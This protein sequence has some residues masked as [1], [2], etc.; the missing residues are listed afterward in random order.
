LW[1]A[2]SGEERQCGAEG[3]VRAGVGRVV[4]VHRRGVEFEEVMVGQRGDRRG[5]CSV[6]RGAAVGI[7]TAR[8][9]VEAGCERKMK[10]E[11][12]SSSAGWSF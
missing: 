5:R 2:L 11:R 4:E 1:H 8:G 12:G 6:D 7:S 9:G 3:V 10:V